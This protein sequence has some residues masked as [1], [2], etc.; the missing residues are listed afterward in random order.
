MPACPNPRGIH[1]ASRHPAR[2]QAGSPRPGVRVGPTLNVRPE[3]YAPVLRAACIDP[4]GM[5]PAVPSTNAGTKGLFVPRNHAAEDAEDGARYTPDGAP[6]RILLV[7]QSKQRRAALRLL[8]EQAR[9]TV[10]DVG[11]GVE[12]TAIAGIIRP[13]VAMIDLGLPDRDG[14][15]LAE[16]LMRAF[17]PV[18]VLVQTDSDG[19]GVL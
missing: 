9:M 15:D 7:D 16:S 13:D 11:S 6:A 14:M 5:V 3:P 4:G 1:T 19:T 10:Y 17:H 2:A 8:L 18:K 12:A